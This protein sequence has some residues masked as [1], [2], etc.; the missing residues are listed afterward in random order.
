MTASVAAP[1]GFCTRASKLDY[2]QAALR[3]QHD[4]GEVACILGTLL[5]RVRGQQAEEDW[6]KNCDD[7]CL[8]LVTCARG[9]TLVVM[10][11]G[12]VT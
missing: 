1:A 11:K 7:V 10:S 5:E 12:L 3:V 2:E 9:S 8:L 4:F 6:A